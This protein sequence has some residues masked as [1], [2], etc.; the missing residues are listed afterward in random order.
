MDIITLKSL[1]FHGR[2]GYYDQEQI[3]GNDFE[4]DVVAY[5]NFRGAIE[6][7]DLSRT[8]NYELVQDA[9]VTIFSGS[10]ERLI[11]TLCSKIG[12][13]IFEKSPAVKKLRVSVRKLNPPINIPADYAEITMT[14]KR[15]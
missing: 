14:W 3:E 6:Q 2:H 11:E 15:Q 7:D 1:K 4:L 13:E 8:F 10:S 12:N 5:G 9:A